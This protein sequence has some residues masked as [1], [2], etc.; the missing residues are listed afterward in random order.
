MGT[1]EG[2]PNHLSVVWQPPQTPN[3]VVTSYTIY[4]FEASDEDVYGSGYLGEADSVPPLMDSLEDITSN[5]TVP[6]E[7]DTLATVGGLDPFTRYA[8]FVVAATSAGEGERSIASSGVTAESSKLIIFDPIIIKLKLLNFHDIS[9]PTSPP[10]SLVIDIVGSTYVSLSWLPPAVPNG[11]IISY[12]ITYNL[13]GESTSVV[14]QTGE[15]YNITG[16]SAFSYYYFTVFA[17]TVIGD[18]P[19]TLPVIQRTAVARKLVCVRVIMY[20]FTMQY[21]GALITVLFTKY[22]N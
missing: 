20:F 2:Q 19:P 1:V 21:D 6:G 8:C 7:S 11:R 15:Q 14:V 17:S 22:E 5:V 9:V 16:L 18:G 4:C 3:G 12:T 10:V 13:T